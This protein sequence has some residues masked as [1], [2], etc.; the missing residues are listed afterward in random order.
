V[1]G[2]LVFVGGAGFEPNR[3]PQGGLV[4]TQRDIKPNPPP[5]TITT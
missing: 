5:A 2:F 1:A 3:G 4:P